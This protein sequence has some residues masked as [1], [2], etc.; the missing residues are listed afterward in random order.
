MIETLRDELEAARDSGR[1]R[2]LQFSVGD[3]ELEL[4]IAVTRRRS[5]EGGLRISVLSLGGTAG[6]DR[7]ATHRLKLMLRPADGDLVVHDELEHH[8]T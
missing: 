8:P 4:Q 5:A 1:D 7:A 6:T 2:G 3:I